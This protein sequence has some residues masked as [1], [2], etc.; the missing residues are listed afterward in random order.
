LA[1]L[2]CVDY[3]VIFEDDTPLN[4]IKAVKPN[5]LVKGGDWK[6]ENIVG[7]DLVFAAG[8]QVISLTFVDGRSTTNIITKIEK[9]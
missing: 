4:L 3:S 8:G 6:P 1:A 5:V 9:D 7:S 2:G